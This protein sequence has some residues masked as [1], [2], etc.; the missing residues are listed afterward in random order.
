[1]PGDHEGSLA[2]T[3]VAVGFAV[4]PVETSDGDAGVAAAM[5]VLIS[6]GVAARPA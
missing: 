4:I 5:P 1:V 3:G 2:E 6:D